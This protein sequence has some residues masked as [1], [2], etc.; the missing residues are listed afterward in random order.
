MYQDKHQ[1]Y[2][3]RNYTIRLDDEKD[4]D[5]YTR[6]A[7]EDNLTQFVKQCAREH[8]SRENHLENIRDEEHLFTVYDARR[9]LTFI[10][11]NGENEIELLGM[12]KG[13]RIKEFADKYAGQFTIKKRELS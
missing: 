6:F 1:T 12:C 5:L 8:I 13:E 2:N 10:L 9:D 7:M 4:K 3:S 11:H